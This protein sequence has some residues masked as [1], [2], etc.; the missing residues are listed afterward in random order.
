MHNKLKKISI[1]IILISVMTSFS[2]VKAKSSTTIVFKD[3]KLQNDLSKFFDY[4]ETFTKEKA[5]EL[6]KKKHYII[7][8]NAKI[9]DLEDLQYFKNLINVFIA[10]NDLNNLEP[11]S[12]IKD[13]TQLDISN[14]SIKG[15]RFERLLKA[16]GRKKKLSDLSLDNNALTDIKILRNI[17]NIKN[18]TAIQMK[19]NKIKDISIL[20][21]TTKLETLDLSNN[22]IT[23]VTPI[24]NLK[25]LDYIDLHNNC[26]IDYKPI[27]K[28]LDKMFDD[29]DY[30]YDRYDFYKNPVDFK[31]NGKTMKFPYL[32]VYYKNQGYAEAIPLFK[33]LGGS[34]KYNKKTG[35][36]TCKYSGKTLV[37]KDFST[38]YTLDGKEKSLEYP[39]RRMQYD[40]AYVPVEDICNVLG[41]K[42]KVVKTR[43]LY[44]SDDDEPDHAPKLV[45]IKK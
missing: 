27:K 41:M 40:L 13:L 18:Y 35:T 34:A 8:E 42:Y 28:L 37:M 39:M 26:I 5:A 25:K 7:L 17:G 29:Y 45:E 9:S 31:Y 12:E 30:S 10:G 3:K 36:L 20:K 24:K 43:A 22:R 2:I 32:T 4:K 16:M 21:G 15:K 11:L 33:A 38:L 6:S 14:N 1:F 44:L 19:S 23:D